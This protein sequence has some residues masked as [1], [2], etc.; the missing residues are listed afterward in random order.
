MAK[1]EM[2]RP[3]GGI[4]YQQIPHVG[5]T[6]ATLEGCE[7]NM[8]A[9][10]WKLVINNSKYLGYIGDEGKLTLK[11][12]YRG[13][14]K[15]NTNDGDVWDEE[16][17][18]L[19]AYKKAMGK[20]HKNVDANLREFLKD[21]RCLCAGIEHYMDKKGVDYESIPSVEEIKKSR[22]ILPVN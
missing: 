4:T 3:E 12:Q 9:L 8:D 22:F 5:K 6:I 13:I 10:I 19:E 18:K 16:I 15:V 17:G 21:V 14:V 7:S 20:Y 2:A 1:N 11:P